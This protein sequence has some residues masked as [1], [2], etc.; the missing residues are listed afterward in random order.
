M[1]KITYT[2]P[3]VPA[4]WIAAHGL[5]PSRIM[6][7]SL[8]TTFPLGRAEGVCPFVQAFA[9]Q[10]LTDNSIGGAVMTTVC[11]QT[12][13]A[14]DIVSQQHKDNIFLMNV[15]ST[16]KSDES[17]NMYIDELKR[18]GR[19]ICRFGGKT[20][21]DKT[22]VKTMIKYDS[23]RKT[24]LASKNSLVPRIY[25]ESIAQLNES[26]EVNIHEDLV[27]KKSLKENIPI[28][29]VGGPLVKYDFQIFD[30]VENSKGK[31]V[32]DATET[33]ERTLP[34]PFNSS[35][36]R[37]KPLAELADAYFGTIPDISNRPN[38]RL[39]DWLKKKI[40]QTKARGII[41]R[42]MIFCDT[43]HS[44]LY[45]LR[46]VLNLPVLDLDE[47]GQIHKSKQRLINRIQAFLEMLK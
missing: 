28:A 31:I 1:K 11:D 4:E 40:F 22:L 23:L 42:R 21:S 7:S 38:D 6:L 5:K 10:L 33:G 25:S 39:Y 20:P 9:H 13:R 46:K 26:G 45:Q 47:D 27:I 41:L 14:Y 16:W 34:R 43:W 37:E 29:L 24:L 17:R 8:D 19:F 12:R 15:P 18:L 36:L 30:M 44:F 3:Y 32:L 35:L 2:C